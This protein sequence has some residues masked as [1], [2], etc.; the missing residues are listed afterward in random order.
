MK[1]F[2]YNN[3]IFFRKIENRFHSRIYKIKI[4]YYSDK[5]KKDIPQAKKNLID[6]QM[7]KRLLLITNFIESLNDNTKKKEISNI[8]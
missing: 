5:Q 6:Y 7:L 3:Y 4:R 2:C 1:F 8:F